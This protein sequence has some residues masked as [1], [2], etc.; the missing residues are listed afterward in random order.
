MEP[1]AQLAAVL[2]APDPHG[3]AEHALTYLMGV[4][5][6]AQGG[7]F[8]LRGHS[9]IPYA[10]REIEARKLDEILRSWDSVRGSLRG[11]DVVRRDDLVLYPLEDEGAMVGLLVL[12]G[13][14]TTI[15]EELFRTFGVAMAKA[16]QL[17]QPAPVQP[18]ARGRVGRETLLLNL[19]RHEWN[20]ARVAR[21]MGVTRR[22]IYLRLRRY[23]IDRVRIPKVKVREAVT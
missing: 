17:A 15:R 1:V 6:A 18:A 21:M 11:G 5:G 14:V 8:G 9:L 3:A 10:T 13:H 2:V 22:T 19:A 23:G 12:G 20:I 4:H 7:V 16:I